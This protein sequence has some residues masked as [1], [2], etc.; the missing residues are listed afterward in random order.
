VASA[1]D[2]PQAPAYSMSEPE[3]FTMKHEL[4]PTSDRE[5]FSFEAVSALFDGEGDPASVDQFLSASA[6]PEA[7]AQW[8]TYALI[9]DVLRAPGEH[10][11][12]SSA[13][14]LAGIRAQLTSQP[15]DS[16]TAHREAETA[17]GTQG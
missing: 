10:R 6:D 9:G 15:P 7:H 14:F 11:L 17:E 13:D 8:S 12:Q 1:G 2:V 5:E 4:Q 16:P 3:I